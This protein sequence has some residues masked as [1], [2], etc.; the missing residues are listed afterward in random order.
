MR[1]VAINISVTVMFA[2]REVSLSRE[3]SELN[4]GGNAVRSA[5]GSTIRRIVCR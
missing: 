3:I 4:S 1:W 2:A 5:C